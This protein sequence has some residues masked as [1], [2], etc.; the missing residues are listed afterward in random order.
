MPQSSLYYSSIVGV[1]DDKVYEH[2]WLGDRENEIPNST[3]WR[4]KLRAGVYIMKLGPVSLSA[5]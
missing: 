3:R 1:K 2:L 4:C 5:D